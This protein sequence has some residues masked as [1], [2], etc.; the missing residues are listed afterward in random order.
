MQRFSSYLL[1][2]LVFSIPA[3]AQE[4]RI[5]KPLAKGATIQITNLSGRVSIAAENAAPAADAGTS[6]A[7]AVP[8]PS[9]A[10]TSTGSITLIATSE[11]GVSESEVKIVVGPKTTVEVLPGFS[12]KQINLTVIVPLRSRVSV[13]TAAGAVDISGNL[14]SVDVTTGK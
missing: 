11:K 1:L 2:L 9:Q 12:S 14:E 5:S 13:E 10:G 6:D 4:Y 3:I 8:S 7:A